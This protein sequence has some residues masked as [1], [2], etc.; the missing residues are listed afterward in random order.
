LSRNLQ[1]IESLQ[2]KNKV[3]HE[4]WIKYKQE[5]EDSTYSKE[6]IQKQKALIKEMELKS[7]KLFDEYKI[8]KTHKNNTIDRI[9]R[10]ESDFETDK[11]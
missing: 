1:N 6:F 4:N 2:D 5:N 7:A 9:K 11:K 3:Y 10:L 8:D